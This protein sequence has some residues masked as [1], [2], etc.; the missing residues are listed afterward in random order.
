MIFAA[1][2]FRNRA[3][4]AEPGTVRPD[5]AWSGRLAIRPGR[6]RMKSINWA[7]VW[8]RLGPIHLSW[9]W[10]ANASPWMGEGWS[11]Q[12][13]SECHRAC[14]PL[15]FELQRG[16]L[17]QRLVGHKVRVTAVSFSKDGRFLAT[18]GEDGTAR[19]W[20]PEGKPIQGGVFQ[21]R[22]GPLSLVAISPDGRWLAAVGSSLEIWDVNTRLPRALR[23]PATDARPIVSITAAR[24]A[25]GSSR[26]M[27]T[28]PFGNGGSRTT[29]F[30]GNH[31]QRRGGRAAHRG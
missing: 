3:G 15:Q 21:G 12:V 28:E 5:T 13:P 19:L 6:T 7:M 10:T 8:T 23:P 11:E 1:A 17:P 26:P 4:Q 31:V 27:T 20:S 16:F 22:S 2:S 25:A 30:G 18:A 24:T 14:A 29:R 9:N